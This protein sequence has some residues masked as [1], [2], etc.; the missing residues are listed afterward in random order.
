V[1]PNVIADQ[2]RLPNDPA[3]TDNSVSYLRR[4]KEQ[5]A[6]ETPPAPGKKPAQPQEAA[7]RPATERRR[8]PRYKCVGSAEII[9]PDTNMRTWGTLTDISLR[10][11]YVE[12]N[13][14]LPVESKIELVL[15]SQSVRFRAQGIVRI[16]YPFLGMGILINKIEPDQRKLLEDLLAVLARATTVANPL[17]ERDKSADDATVAANPTM[18][19]SEIRS[20]FERNSELSRGDFIRIAERCRRT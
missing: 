3:Q 1:D 17:V 9:H 8:S 10:G 15:E 14:T 19:L 12:I 11:C 2:T 4:L 6:P 7:A 16:S 5:S 20:Y 13:S 18:L